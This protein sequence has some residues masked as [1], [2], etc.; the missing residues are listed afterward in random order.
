M[1]S[2]S[3]GAGRAGEYSAHLADIKNANTLS[4]YYPIVFFPGPVFQQY[5][6]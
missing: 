3:L 6:R 1:G 4:L 2:S 5:K